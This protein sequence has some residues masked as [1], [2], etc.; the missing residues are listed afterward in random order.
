MPDLDALIQSTA[1]SAGSLTAAEGVVLNT[2]TSYAE[3]IFVTIPAFS[4]DHS[5]G[6]CS[7]QP[8]GNALPQQGDRCIVVFDEAREPWVPLWEGDTTVSGGGGAPSGPAGGDLAGT[9][10]NPTVPGKVSKTGDTMTGTLVLP[11]TVFP[12][13]GTSKGRFATLPA[14][15]NW[16]GMFMNASFNGTGWVLDDPALWGMFMKLDVRASTDNFAVWRIPPGAGAHTDETPVFKIDASTGN[17]TVVGK[18]SGVANATGPTDALPLGQA[19]LRYPA[20][21]NLPVNVRDHGAT[22]NGTTDDIVALDAA[23]DAAGPGGTI[24]VPTGVYLVSRPWVLLRQQ[25]VIGNNKQVWW[26]SG[27]ETGTTQTDPA[28]RIDHPTCVLKP[29]AGFTGVTFAAAFGGALTVKGVIVV[30]GTDLLTGDTSAR[31]GGQIKGL[32]IEGN[33][34]GTDVDGIV[35]LGQATDWHLEDV[36]IANCTGHGLSLESYQW[37][38]GNFHQ[39]QNMTA[40]R[41]SIHNNAKSGVSSQS[42]QDSIFSHT[43]SHHN[44]EYGWL[45]SGSRHNRLIACAAEQNKWGFGVQGGSEVAFVGCWTDL[46]EQYGFLLQNSGAKQVIQLDG[47]ST[48]RDGRGSNGLAAGLAG[49]GIYGASGSNHGP[50][51][52]TNHNSTIGRLF[53]ADTDGPQIGLD[54][55]FAPDVY[56]DGTLWGRATAISKANGSVVRVSPGTKLVTGLVGAEVTT[57]PLSVTDGG[58][59]EKSINLNGKTFIRDYGAIELFDVNSG[60]LELGELAGNAGAGGA[61]RARLFIKD[62]GAGKTQLCVQFNTGT[63]IVLAT[64]V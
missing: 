5:F 9:Y 57:R 17:I 52:I 35:L 28:S 3:P 38:S 7:W 21:S 13:P 14:V 50:V 25:K 48:H 15:P 60:Y 12:T 64:Q 49:L 42:C 59:F 41:C 36:E 63:P 62:N 39:P 33:R 43:W 27:N 55:N 8:R 16:I 20:R 4:P 46:N 53:A 37:S 30:P 47:C 11:G 26:E 44:Q 45:F 54:C 24:E 18:V 40:F 56:V 51:Y 10:P 34:V 31:W 58:T 19:D 23:R 2:P 29:T 22:G 1:N 61:D 6:P 32:G